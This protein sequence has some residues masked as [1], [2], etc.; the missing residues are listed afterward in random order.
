[1]EPA[2]ALLPEKSFPVHIPG[3]QLTYGRKPAVC[4]AQRSAAPKA[5]F[6]EVKTVSHLAPDAVV[7]APKDVARVNAALKHEI[8]H[9]PTHGIVREGRDCSSLETKASPEAAHYI[10]FAAALPDF[11]ITR[12]MDAP[13]ARIEPEHDLAQR[14]RIP[15]AFGLVLKLNRLHICSLK[16]CLRSLLPH[17]E[18]ASRTE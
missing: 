17:Y 8:L 13:V 6:Y 3:P 12:R 5:A 9:K 16:F 15:K 11:E 10:V 14:C 18:R 1:M 7:L 4:A 2:H